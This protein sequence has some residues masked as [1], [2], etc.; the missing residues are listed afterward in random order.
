MKYPTRIYYTETDKALMW[1]RWQK[2]ESQH[3]I[4]RHF[5]R[6]H[7]SIQNILR[8]TGGIRPTPR[9]RSRLSLTLAEREEISRGV[10]VGRSL[11]SIA[12]S[13]DRAPSTV[14]REIKRNGG[15]RHYRAS[16]AE[17]AAWDRA[18]R[19]KTCKLVENRVLARIVSSKLRKLWS[20]D[21]IAGWLKHTYADDENLQV[22]HETIYRSLF[23]QARG[24]LKKEL[25]QHLRKTRAMRR[26]RHKSLKGEG[27][28]R[29]LGR[30]PSVSDPH[31]LRIEPYPAIGRAT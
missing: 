24:A 30:Y 22:S 18:H 20:P 2:G 8:R 23:I 19:P 12:V 16:N 14:S 28:V 6:S 9:R 10:I 31:R 3:S 1:D 4:G 15:R 5:G 13:L 7:S 25:L 21:Q 27:W 17:Q 29:S 26:S 11:R